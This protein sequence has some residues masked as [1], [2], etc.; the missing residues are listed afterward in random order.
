MDSLPIVSTRPVNMSLILRS[1]SRYSRAG[2]MTVWI[3]GKE[4]E[5]S[6]TVEKFIEYLAGHTEAF[7]CL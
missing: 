1:I 4:Q 7:R 2:G 6:K 5:S 3:R